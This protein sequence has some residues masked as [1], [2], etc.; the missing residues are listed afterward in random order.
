MRIPREAARV[1]LLDPA[2]RSSC[3]ATTT[4]GVGVHW[5]MPDGG[6]EPGETPHKTA[7]RELREETGWTELEPGPPLCAWEHDDTRAGVPVRQHEHIDRAAGPRRGPADHLAAAHTEDKILAWR[8]WP[9][10]GPA[11]APEPLWPPQLPAQPSRTPHAPPVDLGYVASPPP[12]GR[13][14]R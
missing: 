3:S 5:A 8:W 10:D 14:G 13:P 6:L 1:A 7:R 12:A 2:A 4:R 9:P 11:A